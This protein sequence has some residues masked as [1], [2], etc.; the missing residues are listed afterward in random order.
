MSIPKSEKMR[1]CLNIGTFFLL[2]LLLKGGW[3]IKQATAES[4]KGRLRDKERR[5][6]DGEG[7]QTPQNNPPGN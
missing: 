1:V 6:A 4:P 3:K 7:G 2:G 5:L